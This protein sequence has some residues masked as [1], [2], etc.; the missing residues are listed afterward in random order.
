[1]AWGVWNK[2]K[3]GIKKVAGGIGKA[4]SWVNDKIIKPVIKPIANAV[5]PIIDGFVPGLGSTIRNGIDAGSGF[6][7]RM[8]PKLKDFSEGNSMLGSNGGGVRRLPQYF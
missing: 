5:A 3:N 8:T 2:I 6:A 1:M 4:A 7:D